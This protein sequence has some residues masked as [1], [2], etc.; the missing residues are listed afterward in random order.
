MSPDVLHTTTTYDE[1]PAVRRI[2][3]EANPAHLSEEGRY[4][5]TER[6]ERVHAV[7]LSG[8]LADELLVRLSDPLP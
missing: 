4:R 2:A 8:V 6:V 7:Q 5:F 1:L 3:R